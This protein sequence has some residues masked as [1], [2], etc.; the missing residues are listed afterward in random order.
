MDKIRQE[1]AD[2]CVISK[3][4]KS[5]VVI[6]LRLIVRFFRCPLSHTLSF[7]RRLRLRIKGL[8][9][10]PRLKLEG[11]V[12]V[13]WPER[14]RLGS[15]VTLGKDIYLGAWPQAELM[16]GNNSY[17]GRWTI[18][19][20]NQSVVIGNDC[21]IAPGCHITDVNHGIELGEL[22]RKQPLSSKPVLIGNDV[23]IGVGS[24]IL[25]GVTIG[26]GAVIGARSVVTHNVPRG[27]I[28]VGSPAKLLRYRNRNT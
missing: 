25:P 6:F 26:D 12:E 27:A 4:R 10:G 18:I 13:T 23:W 7:V 9:F 19:L 24:S 22:I 11:P 3:L 8:N 20:A 15:D 1:K 16:V 21:L 28:F 14:I 17:V 2:Q 5:P